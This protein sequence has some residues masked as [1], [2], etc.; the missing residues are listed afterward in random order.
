[1]CPLVVARVVDLGAIGQRGEGCQPHIKTHAGI[2]LRQR[3]CLGPYRPGVLSLVL[4]LTQRHGKS[5]GFTLAQG[6]IDP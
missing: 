3:R 5:L 1:L 4:L 6:H 2:S